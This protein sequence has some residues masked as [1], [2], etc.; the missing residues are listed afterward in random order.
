MLAIT[1]YW[2]QQIHKCWLVVAIIQ[3]SALESVITYFLKAWI[4]LLY[5]DEVVLSNIKMNEFY[6]LHLSSS[7]ILNITNLKLE[8]ILVNQLKEV[9][10]RSQS[11]GI[12]ALQKNGII[13]TH[14]LG[15]TRQC[16]YLYTDGNLIRSVEN[17]HR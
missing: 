5:I 13:E 14:R 3:E 16:R 8:V 2:L 10:G 17:L 12:N 7:F 6:L 15:R 4:P 9:E 1:L 11:D